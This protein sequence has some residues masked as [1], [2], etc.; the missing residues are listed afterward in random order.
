MFAGAELTETRAGAVVVSGAFD[1]VGVEAL[2][3]GNAVLVVG[4]GAV[5]GRVTTDGDVEIR[6]RVAE[7][8]TVGAGAKGMGGAS[9]VAGANGIGGAS[10]LAV[11]AMA[12]PDEATGLA[13]VTGATNDGLFD[14][15]ADA[16]GFTV[17]GEVITTVAMG[18]VAM[19]AP[20]AVGRTE[21]GGTDAERTAS[22][23]AVC[24]GGTETTDSETRGN[25][26]T[27]AVGTGTVSVGVMGAGVMRVGVMGVG[28]MGAGV[29]GTAI[30]GNGTGLVDGAMRATGSVVETWG[31]ADSLPPTGKAVARVAVTITGAPS[32]PTP[33]RGR[34]GPAPDPAGTTP[35]AVVFSPAAALGTPGV[36]EGNGAS[37]APACTG[38]TGVIGLTPG[39]EIAPFRAPFTGG[40]SRAC[41]AEAALAGLA[42][43]VLG[44][45]A[46]ERTRPPALVIEATVKLMSLTRSLAI[47]GNSTCEL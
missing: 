33:T 19:V 22:L 42:A 24:P 3:F 45:S 40:R 15:D 8:K 31:L 20:V 5:A 41:G 37:D 32:C 14:G 38:E 30:E 2:L 35:P 28:V 6:T 27:G 25:V 7:F 23:T 26:G 1:V 12:L 16:D 11:V 9:E 10:G 43:L 29:T 36:G 13:V 34:A 21:L 17:A 46:A 4:A 44:L 47:G 18:T 39:E